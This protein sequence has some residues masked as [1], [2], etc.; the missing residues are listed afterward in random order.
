VISWGQSGG[1]LGRFRLA[2]LVAVAVAVVA[3]PAAAAGKHKPRLVGFVYTETNDPAANKV[4]VFGRY[5]DGRLKQRQTLRTGGR[6][7]QEQQ[8]GCT[9]HCPILDTQGEVQLA[10]SG[11]F[12]AAVNA[13]SNTITVFRVTGRG[14]R[15]TDRKSSGGVFPNSLTSHGDLLYVLNSNS[16]NIVGFRVSAAGKLK[17]IKR[18]SRRLTSNADSGAPRQIGFDQTGRVLVVTLFSSSGGMSPSHTIDTFVVHSSGRPGAATA[19]NSSMPVPFA[20][21]FDA[22]A[23][24]MILAHASG[25]TGTYKVSRKGVVKPIELQSSHGEAPCWVAITGSGRHAFVVNTGG[26][27]AT[28]PSVAGY[29]LKRNGKLSFLGV[30]PNPLAEHFKTD[31]ALSPD[32]NYLYVLAPGVTG[33]PSHIDV[34]KIGNKGSLKLIQHTPNKLATGVSGIAVR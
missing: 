9:A 14:L 15:R 31:D 6:G 10:G 25:F 26:S 30:T 13:G 24:H 29:A 5:S 27:L 33:G 1:A 34:Y 22:R 4:V 32:N 16:R 12:L 11:R 2:A 18:S 28:P 20:F 7:G 8:P 23:N 3:I 19:Y 21:A 17:R